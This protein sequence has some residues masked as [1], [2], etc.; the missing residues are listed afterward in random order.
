MDVDKNPMLAINRGLSPWEAIQLVA[1][2]HGT[3]S[4]FGL[5][6]NEKNKKIVDEIKAGMKKI[7]ARGMVYD[8]VS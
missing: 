5:E 1:A 7:A 4:D 2:G 8:I 6:D 3:L